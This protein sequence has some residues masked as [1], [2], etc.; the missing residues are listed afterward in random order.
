MG[1]IRDT[2]STG[3]LNLIFDGIGRLILYAFIIGC[4]V[5]GVI[6]RIIYLVAK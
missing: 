2:S 3:L 6:G 4:V 5:A 1:K